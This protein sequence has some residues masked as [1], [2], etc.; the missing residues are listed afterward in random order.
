MDGPNR[1]AQRRFSDLP[2]PQPDSRSPKPASR[3]PNPA[4]PSWALPKAEATG[5]KEKDQRG[6]R[7]GAPKGAA[8]PLPPGGQR[9]TMGEI[10]RKIKEVEERVHGVTTE[11]CLEALR[12]NGWELPKTIQL[13]KVN[14][15]FNLSSLSWD[16]CRRIL[17]KHRWNLAMASRYVLSRGL[18]T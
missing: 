6:G 5:A 2:T 1:A 18:R 15:L 17:E 10:E 14:Q 7:A 16:E 13:L 9:L 3:I 4:L 12:M 8:G 11:E